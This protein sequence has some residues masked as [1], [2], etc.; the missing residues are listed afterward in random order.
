MQRNDVVRGREEKM[1]L[2]GKITESRTE[3]IHSK[4]HGNIFCL[5]YFVTR[6]LKTRARN[7]FHARVFCRM[8]KN[9]IICMKKGLL[10]S[11]IERRKT[12]GERVENLVRRTSL[13]L[14][15]SDDEHEGS[16][17]HPSTKHDHVE[18]VWID[19]DAFSSIRAA[20]IV[21]PGYWTC[22]LRTDSAEH[23]ESSKVDYSTGSKRSQPTRW[24][25]RSWSRSIAQPG[26]VECDDS[27]NRRCTYFPCNLAWHSEDCSASSS[28][29]PT[30]QSHL[31][32]ASSWSLLA[33]NERHCERNSWRS[34]SCSM[35]NRRQNRTENSTVSS[36]FQRHF[37][38]Q[39]QCPTR[40]SL[41]TAWCDDLR[42]LRCRECLC[43]EL[44][45]V[46]RVYPCSRLRWNYGVATA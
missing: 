43:S 29:Y 37:H 35:M 25:Q 32:W 20:G 38:R 22:P 21:E 23:R 15:R 5:H 34:E 41:D 42:C 28:W 1:H 18:N 10:F 7:F 11:P 4:D 14:P 17:L 26:I 24:R 16:G 44:S 45:Q 3:Y 19:V 9:L 46:L 8:N 33:P 12:W 31:R 13:Q 36:Q 2:I 6:T 40:H 39:R 30:S 27:P